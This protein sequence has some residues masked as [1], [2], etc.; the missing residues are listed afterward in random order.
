MLFT[1]LE[2]PN[3]NEYAT[4]NGG[5]FLFMAPRTK[6]PKLTDIDQ[7]IELFLKKNRIFSKTTKCD[8]KDDIGISDI[9]ETLDNLSRDTV[10]TIIFQLGIFTDHLERFLYTTDNYTFILLDENLYKQLFDADF[11]EYK[12]FHISFFDSTNGLIVK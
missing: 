11:S 2:Y 10:K 6:V 9:Y 5:V 7:S 8:K 4:S 3:L 12:H 1:H